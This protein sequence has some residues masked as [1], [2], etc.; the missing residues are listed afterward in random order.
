VDGEISPCAKVLALD[1]RTLIAKLGDVHH[2]L[3]HLKN[4]YNLVTCSRLQSACEREGIAEDFRGGCFASNYQ[5]RGDIF[6]PDRQDHRF[7]VLK[8][9]ACAGCSAHGPSPR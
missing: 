6:V 3:T 5:S 8:R 2:G 7:S 4:R 1:N 9:S